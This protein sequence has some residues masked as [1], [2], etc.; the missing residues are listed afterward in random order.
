MSIENQFSVELCNQYSADPVC[1]HCDG[2]LHHEH[3]CV[4]QNASVQYA[5]QVISDPWH[6]SREDPLILHPLGA[7]WTA[8]Q[9]LPGLQQNEIA[10]TTLGL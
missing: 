5:Y 3:W 9:I 8:K 4:T 6:L 7:A 10:G 2:V 1:G